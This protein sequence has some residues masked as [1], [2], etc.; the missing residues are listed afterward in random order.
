[1]RQNFFFLPGRR[2]RVGEGRTQ[3]VGPLPSHTLPEP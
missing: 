1:M 2:R 3:L